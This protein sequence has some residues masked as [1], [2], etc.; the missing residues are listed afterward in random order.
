MTK[1]KSAADG[2]SGISKELDSFL[3]EFDPDDAEDAQLRT[4]ALIS[5]MIIAGVLRESRMVK[6]FR[7]HIA[8]ESVQLPIRDRE[9]IVAQAE[10][11]H[12]LI[13]SYAGEPDEADMDAARTLLRGIAEA[14]NSAINAKMNKIKKEPNL[15]GDIPGQAE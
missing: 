11:F 6:K 12:D 10:M 8:L 15:F 13:D 2:L 14:L 5:S 7:L 4:D 3:D 9:A 1:R